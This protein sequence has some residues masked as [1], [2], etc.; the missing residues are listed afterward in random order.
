[1][2]NYWLDRK[3]PSLE[4]AHEFSKEYIKKY[5]DVWDFQTAL[6]DTIKEKYENI[7]TKVVHKRR[8]DII[9]AE[10]EVKR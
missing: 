1:M 8:N 4:A 9:D 7:Y 3:G 2:K 5:Y 6:G 10:F